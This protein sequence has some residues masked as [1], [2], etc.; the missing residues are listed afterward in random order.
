M[1]TSRGEKHWLKIEDYE[2]KMELRDTQK[3]NA[4]FFPDFLH[5]LCK[6]LTSS[7]DLI[8]RYPAREQRAMSAM[9]SVHDYTNDTLP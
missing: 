7:K 6:Q 2:E 4:L 5:I 3:L 8:G 1:T 9:H